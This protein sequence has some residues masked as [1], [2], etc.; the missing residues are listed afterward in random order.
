MDTCFKITQDLWKSTFNED[1]FFAGGMFRGNPPNESTYSKTDCVYLIN[2]YQYI[3]CELTD[4]YLTAKTLIKP[5]KASYCFKIE[6]CFSEIKP[7]NSFIYNEF[8]S[9]IVTLDQENNNLNLILTDE[10]NEFSKLN[11]KF[12]A[13]YNDSLAKKLSNNFCCHKSEHLLQS[14][15]SI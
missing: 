12:I 8:L 9:R 1:F 7:S 15:K 6:H 11:F 10:E 13:Q 14:F 3:E 2:C 4:I 5:N